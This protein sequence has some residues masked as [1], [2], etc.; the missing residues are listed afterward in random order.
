MAIV[1]EQNVTPAPHPVGKS[2]PGQPNRRRTL[3]IAAEIAAVVAALIAG[4]TLWAQL[5]DDRSGATDSGATPGPSSPRAPGSPTT[6]PVPSIRY[7]ADLEP[8]AGKS[9]LAPDTGRSLRIACASGQSNDRDRV[10]TYPLYGRYRSLHTTVRATGPA[11]KE[12]QI[13]LEALWDLNPSAKVLVPI[14][15][16]RELTATL[17]GQRLTLRLTCTSPDA[18]VQLDEARLSTAAR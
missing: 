16:A 9:A 10:V 12:T 14:D 3:T 15:D 17:S 2:A 6:A 13:Q 5:P 11:P 1:T 8:L 7:L 18:I 4:I